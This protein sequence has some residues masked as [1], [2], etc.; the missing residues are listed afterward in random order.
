MSVIDELSTSIG[1]RGNEPN[2]A[3]AKKC[4]ENPEHLKELLPVLCG[5]DKNISADAAE[6]MTEVSNVHPELVA[7]YAKY[8]V[9]LM[10]HKNNRT[11]WEAMHA[12]ANVA[13]LQKE[14]IQSLLADLSDIVEKDA[15]IIVRDYAVDAVSGYAGISSATAKEAFPVLLHLLR[16]HEERH[17]G[18]ALEGLM[19]VIALQPGYK[20][21]VL[22]IA[23]EFSLN[24][25]ASVAK[26]GKKLLKNCQ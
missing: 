24:K 17:A 21:Q 26:I 15:S 20:K 13:H 23:E 16:L 14:L 7:P 3:V 6:V 12:I 1:V 25:K 2:K 11:R 19:R 4:L 8:L 18:R 22:S 5:K 10:R 9:Q